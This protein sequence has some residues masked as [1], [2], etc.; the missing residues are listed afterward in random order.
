MYVFFEVIKLSVL[1]DNDQVLPCFSQMMLKY[2]RLH[3]QH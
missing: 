3:N 1:P 2:I